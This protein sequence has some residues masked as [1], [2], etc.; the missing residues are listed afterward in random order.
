MSGAS[1]A[2][3]SIIET[4]P[5]PD[6][7]KG[8]WPTYV[9]SR[10]SDELFIELEAQGFRET[11]WF[12]RRRLLKV[13][14]W[15]DPRLVFRFPPQHF[16]ETAVPF[17]SL[18]PSESILRTIRLTPSRPGQVVF[19][20]PDTDE[21]ELSLSELLA[22][23]R[24]D[25]VVPD[26]ETAGELYALDA[27][28]TDLPVTQI[29]MPWGVTLS[30]LGRYGPPS[31]DDVAEAAR[32]GHFVWKH[33]VDAR[34]V[35]HWSVLWSTAIQNVARSGT[36]NR[37]EVLEVRGFRNKGDPTGS[38]DNGTYEVA[39]EDGLPQNEYPEADGRATPLRNLDRIDIAA[40]LSRRFPYTGRPGSVPIE[41]GLLRY[42]SAAFNPSNACINACYADGRAIEI[43]EFRLSARGGSLELNANWDPL[44]S[45]A[46]S[47][48]THSATLGRDQHVRL[49]DAG[50]LFPFGIDAQLVILSERTFTRDPNGHFV[51]ILV[52]RA[53]LQIPQ[54][55]RLA[56]DHP[57]SIFRE[58]SITTARTPPLDLPVSGD[59]AAYR[60]YDF[61]LPMVEG[62]PFPFEHL[63]TDWTGDRHSAR[64]PMYF[65][66]NKA[67]SANGLIWEP[68]HDWSHSQ[69]NA[70]CGA[71][72][73]GPG[74]TVHAI[75]KSGDG[76]RVVDKQ[77]NRFDYRFAHYGDSLIA[78]AAPSRAGDTTQ[79]V[80]WVEWVRGRVPQ[81]GAGGV[82]ERPFQPRART[83]K[84]RL[85]GIGE[86]SGQASFVIGTFRDT[87]FARFPILD[88]EPTA[89][90]SIYFA[91]LA[92]ARDAA[93]HP[94]SAYVH[95][96]EHRE[97]VGEASA[98]SEE[99]DQQRR[100]RVRALYYGTSDPA[101]RISLA[102]FSALG[103]EV[104]FGT[105]SSSQSTG[106]ITVP[107]THVSTISRASGPTGD[108][109]FNERKWKGYAAEKPK[110]EA[111]NRLD[112]SAF[113]RFTRP[114]LDH[115]PFD[116][117]N[118][119]NAVQQ[120]ARQAHGMMG[121]PL[122]TGLSAAALP[123]VPSLGLGL[124]DLFGK[125]A[126]IIPG[127]A[128]DDIF[129]R[130][131]LSDDV[132]PRAAAGAVRAEPFAWNF[133]ITGIDWLLDAIGNESGQL[134]IPQLVAAVIEG[135][136]RF[137]DAM[138]VS[139]GMKA[140]LE[141]ETKSFNTEEIGPLKFTPSSNT[142]FRIEAIARVDLGLSGLPLTAEALK[143]EP[144]DPEISSYAEFRDFK[145]TVFDA[146]EISFS[147]VSFRLSANGS[148][149]FSTN[150]SDVGFTGPLEFIAQLSE[151]LGKLGSDSGIDTDLSLHTIRISQKIAFPPTQG[152]PLFIGPAVI[153][154]LVLRWGVVIPLTGRDVL[155][156]DFALSSREKPL[157]IYV[158]PWYGGKAHILLEVTTRGVRLLEVSMEYGALVPITWGVANGEASLTAG[159]FYMVERVA[160]GGRVAFRAFVKASANLD[161]VGIIHFSG[162]IYIGLSYI[163]EPGSRIIRGE[164]LI[165]VSI[166]IGWVRYSYSFSAEHVERS[167]GGDALVTS[168]TEHCMRTLVSKQPGEIDLFG[169]DFDAVRREAFERFLAGYTC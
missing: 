68:G 116:P 107:D 103:N 38:I 7:C 97:L 82:A 155:A 124:A 83:F 61:F 52:K 32:L 87:R 122:P 56:L 76:L 151:I 139:L 48:W 127:L 22:W 27:A 59:P 149:D 69:A 80:K 96:L 71:P 49:V 118:D 64:M 131:L 121:Y 108:A 63:G 140:S 10:E 169:G 89:P 166:K 28:H 110:L 65:V 134:S 125:D 148:K 157:T 167:G 152:Q 133:E 104:R 18:P 15:R 25:L 35:G 14:C 78:I 37:F 100:E 1:L 58:I 60:D 85:Q 93:L 142:Q 141:W 20:V 75:P 136:E 46:L 92:T 117:S 43:E 45:C 84:L 62:Q 94:A 147:D 34:P 17:N 86:F 135:G 106:G 115:S 88:P 2:G 144:K 16:A 47:G 44:P 130:V 90:E 79:R 12:S 73:A 51:A 145:I 31:E 42:E 159:I 81:L 30:P 109:S 19:R 13:E 101:S 36:A 67:T 11:R 39:Y 162:L 113:S 21:I 128:F 143:L 41:T 40:N 57:E 91:N 70:R 129:R 55:N 74:D 160:G 123:A 5:D 24:F 158:P 154:N 146:I 111:V 4:K 9:L 153:T 50:F 137:E 164:A 98:P 8:A 99:S 112:Y 150:I 33:S 165:R 126:Q 119:E 95:L 120:L 54:P 53:F 161:V 72:P 114:N 29:E 6:H 105:S 3:C 138:P 77:W 26:L 168:A 156:A 132:A 102:L 23:E 66:S 163:D